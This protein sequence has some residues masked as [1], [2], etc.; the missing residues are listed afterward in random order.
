[1]MGPAPVPEGH[2]RSSLPILALPGRRAIIAH[3]RFGGA[4]RFTANDLTMS[5]SV[6]MC[7]GGSKLTARESE[8]EFELVQESCS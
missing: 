5:I 2:P 3:F 7:L 1:M 4:Q 6:A 8:L